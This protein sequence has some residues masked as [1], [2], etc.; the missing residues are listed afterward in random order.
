MH[1]LLKEGHF[2]TEA[3]LAKDHE[4]GEHGIQRDAEVI[5]P[6]H[7][8]EKAERI[9]WS[10]LLPPGRIQGEQNKVF[11]T[12]QI[13]SRQESMDTSQILGKFNIKVK[14][15]PKTNSTIKVV[16]FHMEYTF[17]KVCDIPIYGII[18]EY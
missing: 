7:P 14:K 18:F 3:S 12:G 4:N 16:N 9:Y 10:L 17:W 6:V 8:E 2:L 13:L 15:N 5:G 11:L 1:S